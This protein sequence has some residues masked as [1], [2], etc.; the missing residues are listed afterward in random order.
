MTH[1]HTHTHTTRWMGLKWLRF[2]DEP[3]SPRIWNTGLVWDDY[4]VYI[5][6]IATFLVVFGAHINISFI[7]SK[8]RFSCS[9]NGHTGFPFQSCEYWVWKWLPYFE[10][11]VQSLWD[12]YLFD[13]HSWSH[14]KPHAT[15]NHILQTLYRCSIEVSNRI[16]HIYLNPPIR[17]LHMK[18]SHA[19][20]CGHWV[21][22]FGSW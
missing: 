20:I 11:A 9:W 22:G 14:D 19:H 4:E 10:H 2:S 8:W 16:W 1:L 18:H 5:E 3:T 15:Q 6:A 13:I 17:P 12:T 21:V 7:V